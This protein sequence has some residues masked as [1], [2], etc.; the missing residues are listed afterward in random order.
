MTEINSVT[1]LTNRICTP[2]LLHADAR[3]E[4]QTSGDVYHNVYKTRVLYTNSTYSLV[5]ETQ[6]N[7]LFS[8]LDWGYTYTS[9]L[10][11]CSDFYTEMV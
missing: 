1:S 10:C 2:V 3:L 5:N 7:Y 9:S 4:A 8:I 11:M 6:N